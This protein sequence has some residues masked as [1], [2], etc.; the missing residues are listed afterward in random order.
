M[1]LRKRHANAI[2]FITGLACLGAAACVQ[3]GHNGAAVTPGFA[4]FYMDEGATAKLA[5]GAPNSDDVGLMMECKKG[6]H[7][8]DVS[9]VARS[10]AA[11]TM[12]LA[13]AGRAQK[14]AGTP[15]TGDEAAVLVAHTRS[16]APPLQNF[17]QSGRIDVAYAGQSY[18]I[19]ANAQERAGVRRFFEACDR[20]V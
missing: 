10:G 18:A 11:P 19:A 17:K 3:D 8:I 20:G 9:D 13:S 7:A 5:Y 14:L 6:S 4:L 16:D 12:T 15:S 1:N 2:V